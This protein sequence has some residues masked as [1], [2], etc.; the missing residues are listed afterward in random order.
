MDRLCVFCLKHESDK[1][2][3]IESNPGKGCT[4]GYAH[5]YLEPEVQPEIQ[6]KKPDKKLCV[7]CGL[8]PK[9]PLASTNNCEHTYES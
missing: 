6:Q 4:Y 1:T 5:E 8:H 9:N 7:K 3:W 2:P